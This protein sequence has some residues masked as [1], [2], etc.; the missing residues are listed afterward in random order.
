MK[1]PTEQELRELA[2]EYAE[3]IDTVFWMAKSQSHTNL[4]PHFER[5]YSIISAALDRWA[6]TLEFQRE[7]AST[8]AALNQVLDEIFPKQKPKKGTK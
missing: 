6:D 8:T 5:R 1:P 2:L 4:N 7:M 3:R